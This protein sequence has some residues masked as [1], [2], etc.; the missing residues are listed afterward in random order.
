MPI[1]GLCLLLN[2]RKFNMDQIQLL[3]EHLPAD[4]SEIESQLLSHFASEL[5]VREEESH[6]G[7][8]IYSERDEEIHAEVKQTQRSGRK[9]KTNESVIL[10]KVKSRARQ[11]KPHEVDRVLILRD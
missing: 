10:E 2:V 4:P 8:E 9:K 5:G 7:V 6:F 3:R 1:F 11:R